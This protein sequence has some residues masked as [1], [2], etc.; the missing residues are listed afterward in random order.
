VPAEG[1]ARPRPGVLAARS[2][3]FFPRRRPALVNFGYL[4]Q[5]EC[6][7]SL[8]VPV[9]RLLPR[10]EGFLKDSWIRKHVTP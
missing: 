1:F 7:V 6:R 2:C 8:N 3:R 5:A 9:Q 10:L 4:M